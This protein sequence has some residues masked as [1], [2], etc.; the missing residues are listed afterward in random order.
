MPTKYCSYAGCGAKFEY[1]YDC[2]PTICPKCHRELAKAFSA[3]TSQSSNQVNYQ[4]SPN[5][6]VGNLNV[7]HINRPSLKNQ[8][9][10]KFG[11]NYNEEEN[12][13]SI[14]VN[15]NRHDDDYVDKNAM[16]AMADELAASLNPDSFIPLDLTPEVGGGR[17]F[18]FGDIIKEAKNSAPT[19]KSKAKIAPKQRVR[20][21]HSA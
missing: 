6:N 10:S 1:S 13:G 18:K 2:L 12:E 4:T 8:V 19:P 5:P 20:K 17:S 3:I 15:Q 11:K 9:M 7:Q 21:S 14:D 16:Y